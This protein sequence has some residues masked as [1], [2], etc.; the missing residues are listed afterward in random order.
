MKQ[1]QPVYLRARLPVVATG[2]ALLLCATPRLARAAPACTATD[3]Y[4]N[5]GCQ[6]DVAQY[7]ALEGIAAGLWLLVQLLLSAA[8]WMD[9]LR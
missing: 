6:L 4:D 3:A 2:A 8:Y 9:A 7:D 5:V 1:L